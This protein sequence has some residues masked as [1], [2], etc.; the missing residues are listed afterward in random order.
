MSG[1]AVKWSGLMLFIGV[2][3]AAVVLWTDVSPWVAGAILVAW[4][5]IFVALWPKEGEA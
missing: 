2:V 1:E 3:S 4:L 5:V